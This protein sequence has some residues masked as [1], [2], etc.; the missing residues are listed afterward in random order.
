MASA[1]FTVTYTT[2]Y[3][4]TYSNGTVLS[5]PATVVIYEKNPH[6]IMGGTTLFW[7]NCTSPIVGSSA[8]LMA[9]IVALN[10]GSGGGGGD[11]TAAN[12]ATQIGLATTSNA[13]LTSID[14]KTASGGATSANQ[15]TQIGLITTSNSLLSS[16]DTKAIAGPS[17]EAAQLTAQ[18]SFDTLVARQPPLGVT[19]PALSSSVVL[20]T[21]EMIDGPAAQTAIQNNMLVVG[22]ATATSCAP[23]ASAC[24]EIVSTATGGTWIIEQSLDNVNFGPIAIYEQG[25]TS[26]AVLNA[27]ITATAS[28]RRFA[29]AIPGRFLR[30]RIVTTLTGGSAQ[31]R[32]NMSQVPFSQPVMSVVQATAA[33][34]QVQISSALPAGTNTL[35]NVIALPSNTVGGYGTHTRIVVGS[36]AGMTAAS[37]VLT[38][39]AAAFGGFYAHNL[40]ATDR[41]FHLYNSTTVTVGTTTP[42]YSFKLPAAAAGVDNHIYF[43]SHAL[44]QRFTTG[45]CFSITN[46]IA[47]VP[48]TAVTLVAGG[49][50]VITFLR[51]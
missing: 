29:M 18:T 40:E 17:T 34:L 46:D 43:P 22:G 33:N 15:G 8:A 23:W 39:A 19:T 6:V 11:A 21:D 37:Q 1:T 48:A 3:L 35:G 25:V 42:I 14:T 36:G 44:N 24:V 9:A 28:T 47:T 13:L 2:S 45:I 49:N 41:W 5:Y 27:A 38:A 31:A 7:Q 4:I 32:I 10:P 20:S 16:L 30:V 51:L 26:G 50:A 12:Q